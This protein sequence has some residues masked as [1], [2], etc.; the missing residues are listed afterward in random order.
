MNQKKDKPECFGQLEKV[1]PMTASGLR[2][3]PKKCFETCPLKTDCLRTA[4]TTQQA[5][6]VEEEIIDRGSKTGAI[7]FFERWSRKKQVHRKK[8]KQ[9]NAEEK[10]A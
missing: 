2:E 6:N 10:D 5:V 3:T 7:G 8:Q 4:M 9:A 1:F